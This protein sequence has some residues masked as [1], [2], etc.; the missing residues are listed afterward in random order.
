MVTNEQH[1]QN[2]KDFKELN[3]SII[4]NWDNLTEEF[5]EKLKVFFEKGDAI[6]N[7]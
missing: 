7:S 1:E 5:K 6:I 3:N 2:L 4:E